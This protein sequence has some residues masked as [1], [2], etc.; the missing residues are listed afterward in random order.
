MALCAVRC[1]RPG[2]FELCLHPEINRV[3]RRILGPWHHRTMLSKDIRTITLASICGLSL[4]FLAA[5][6]TTRPAPDT[7]GLARGQ[8]AFAACAAEQC[9]TLNLDRMSLSSYENLSDLSHVRA[10]M[11]GWTDFS[12]LD[13][14][15][16]MT[17]LTELHIGATMVTDISGIGALENLRLVHIQ[18]SQVSD[19]GPL[20]DLPL[21]EELAIGGRGEVDLSVLTEIPSLTSL[22]LMGR[23]WDLADLEG[24]P[25]LQSI[26]IHE[27]PANADLSVLASLPQLRSV[28]IRFFGALVEVDQ[29]Q[30]D[31]LRARGI[32]VNLVDMEIV[33][34]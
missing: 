18:S 6:Q 1:L 20:A 10:L 17:Q 21:L 33:L 34:C 24:Q 30:I 32:E 27:L 31:A 16:G 15:A 12:T 4:G 3:L 26:Y 13:D 14:I 28:D 22:A 2:W 8:A 19:Y 5:C 29:A 7:S 9:E 23:G 11:V 25:S